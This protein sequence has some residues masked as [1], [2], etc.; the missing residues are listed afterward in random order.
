MNEPT[1]DDLMSQIELL[2]T[3]YKAEQYWE[4]CDELAIAHTALEILDRPD[5]AISFA[6]YFCCPEFLMAQPDL[7]FY[8]RNIAMLSDQS[9]NGIGLDVS[10]V[11]M[12]SG[13]SRDRAAEIASFLNGIVSSVIVQTGVSRYRHIELFMANLSAS[14]A[15]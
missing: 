11:E 14:Q 1:L 8:Y 6:N 5:L 3:S 13:L 4:R 9:M 12:E 7:L 15:S 10:Q 2:A